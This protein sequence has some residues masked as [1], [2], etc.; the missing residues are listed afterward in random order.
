MN[1]S[2]QSE[3]GIVSI[4]VTMIS[5]IVISLIVLGFADIVRN[6]QRSSLDDVLSSQAYYAAESGVNDARAAMET[7]VAAGS[8][9]V[10]KT[11]CAND[12][13][14]TFNTSL[15][16]AHNVSYPCLLINAAP[17]TLS[18]NVGY[19]STVIPLLSNG[20][21]FGSITMTWNVENG[22][23]PNLGSCYP[24]WGNV[25]NFLVDQG[26]GQWNCNFPVIRMDL[27]D[28]NSAM[29][30]VSWNARTRTDFL[31]P[32]D[33][34]GGGN[35]GPGDHG[36]IV[37]ASCTA[38]ANTCTVKITGLG[39]TNYYMRL[40]TLY[41][42]NSLLTLKANGA[43]FTGAQAVID[44]TGKAQDV[45]RR[46]LVAVDLTDANSRKLPSNALTIEDSVCKQFGVTNKSFDVY[47]T[48]GNGGENNPLCT[49]QS[50]GTPG[51]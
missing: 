1:H 29:T 38:P 33:T 23:P 11:S 16:A 30:R 6:E 37:P 4:M 32:V 35:A 42:T 3:Q 14:Y 25:P 28:A 47:T 46:I 41:R 39:G 5:L 26:P 22:Q 50:I 49:K 40:T 13:N 18:Y 24:H 9:V 20:P 45:L 2:R 19:T 12:S 44:S 10:D 21:A 48:Q 8:P 43:N 31:V 34:G 17:S 51:P 7:L 36:T 15:D 27:L